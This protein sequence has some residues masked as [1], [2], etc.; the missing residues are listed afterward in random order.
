MPQKNIPRKEW[1]DFCE[2]FTQQHQGWLVTLTDVQRHTND[3][4]DPE[5]R[6]VA[7]NLALKHITA[8]RDGQGHNVGLRIVA[9][10]GA[11]R[12]THLVLDPAQI[13]LERT[14]YGIDRGLRI[15]DAQDQSTVV[16]FNL[17]RIS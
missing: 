16:R 12:I 6:L 5:A 7:R 4:A 11:R 1:Q 17:P 13:H 10:D 8:E 9:G 15:R 2:E 14:N 3:G